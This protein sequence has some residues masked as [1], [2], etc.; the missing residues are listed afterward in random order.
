MLTIEQ[1]REVESKIKILN[2]NPGDFSLDT[3]K[4]TCNGLFK[5][6]HPDKRVG[7]SIEEINDAADQF[8]KIK[9]T[10]SWLLN[11]ER[12]AALTK[13]YIAERDNPTQQQ[14]TS[15][16]SSNLLTDT[17]SIGYSH[18]RIDIK[19]HCMVARPFAPPIKQA[20]REEIPIE[21]NLISD[22]IRRY[23]TMLDQILP[24]VVGGSID[25]STYFDD[26]HHSIKTLSIQK[27][28]QYPTIQYLG[29]GDNVINKKTIEYIVDLLNSAPCLKK[30]ENRSLEIG[31]RDGSIEFTWSDVGITAIDVSLQKYH[32]Y[33]ALLDKLMES[34]CPGL[35][36]IKFSTYP[37]P[38]RAKDDAKIIQILR[39]NAASALARAPKALPLVASSS[40]DLGAHGFFGP[41]TSVFDK[42]IAL[43]QYK[44]DGRIPTINH[45][46]LMEGCNSTKFSDGVKATENLLGCGFEIDEL[47]NKIPQPWTLH[48]LLNNASTFKEHINSL[49]DQNEQVTF[50]LM[51]L[52][53]HPDEIHEIAGRIKS[54]TFRW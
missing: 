11:D 15:S 46:N 31:G 39:K 24:T 19:F 6:Y 45:I 23:G 36:S 1:R 33:D 25:L 52:N 51:L 3:I 9:E 49:P 12:G 32:L 13:D 54:S 44:P 26:M 10:H 22:S 47:I 20:T 27:I 40:S 21:S 38:T 30:G 16:S 37:S 42:L 43:K 5:K 14:P 34:D 48:H 2:L 17:E 4:A 18:Y 41:T 29:V 7:K 28:V 8:K 53:T 50:R 35:K